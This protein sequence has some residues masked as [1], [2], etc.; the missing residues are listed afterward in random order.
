MLPAW[1][2]TVFPNFAAV[3]S[4]PLNL[5]TSARLRTEPSARVQNIR[6]G[7]IRPRRD[8]IGYPSRIIYIRRYYP[9]FSFEKENLIGTKK[10]WSASVRTRAT[11]IAIPT[12]YCPSI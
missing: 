5:I 11:P 7:G 6:R 1:E 4:T 12:L 8:L 2:A 10:E 9:S 3:P